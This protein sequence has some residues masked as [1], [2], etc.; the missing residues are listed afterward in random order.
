MTVVFLVR[1]QQKFGAIHNEPP[2]PLKCEVYGTTCIF[3]L[4]YLVQK[5]KIVF[6]IDKKN[7]GRL[8]QTAPRDRNIKAGLL[9]LSTIQFEA[10][11]F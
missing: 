8:M 10:L 9:I 4:I 2:R 6:R 1:P 3:Q 11:D 7:W 5:V